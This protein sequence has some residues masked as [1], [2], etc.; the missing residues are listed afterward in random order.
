LNFFN[1]LSR[2]PQPASLCHSANRLTN[3]RPSLANRLTAAEEG[4]APAVVFVSCFA[5]LQRIKVWLNVYFAKT[6]YKQL[7]ALYICNFAFV[8]YIH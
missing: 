8:V 2:A 3:H 7:F 5:I 1:S 4:E 6:L